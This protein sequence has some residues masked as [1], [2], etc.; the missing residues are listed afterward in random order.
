MMCSNRILKHTHTKLLSCWINRIQ[1]VIKF[2]VKIKKNY[3]SIIDNTIKKLSS[4]N[5]KEMY[6][7]TSQ[8]EWSKRTLA[9]FLIFFHFYL[10]WWSNLKSSGLISIIPFI[11]GWW[12]F[13]WEIIIMHIDLPCHVL[14][15]APCDQFLCVLSDYKS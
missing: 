3:N 11:L 5:V 13:K 4:E 15:S 12:L 8:R 10:S 2:T 14:S 1:I 6:R 9:Y 7:W